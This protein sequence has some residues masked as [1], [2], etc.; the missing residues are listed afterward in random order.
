M[1]IQLMTL[2]VTEFKA[3]CLSVLERVRSTGETVVITKRGVVIAHV[4]PPGGRA[5][6]TKL[7]T[8]AGS[9]KIQGDILGPVLPATVWEVEARGG[10]PREWR[11]KPKK[12][13][14]VARQRQQRE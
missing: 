3:K 5:P 11:S 14:S 2:S 1:Y 10:D 6:R 12:P 4:S 9:V 7:D 13:S 8:L